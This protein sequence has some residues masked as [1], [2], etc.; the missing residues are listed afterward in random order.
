MKACPFLFR[1]AARNASHPGSARTVP[2]VLEALLHKGPL[3]VNTVSP[4]VWLTPRSISVAVFH[5]KIT[6]LPLLWEAVG[7]GPR[8]LIKRDDQPGSPWDSHRIIANL[9]IVWTGR[10]SE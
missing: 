2:G 8:L 9:L 10:H 6:E 5:A 1:R 3:P 7:D 4:K